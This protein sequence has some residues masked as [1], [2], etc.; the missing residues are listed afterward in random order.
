VHLPNEMSMSTKIISSTTV[1]P[2]EAM[3]KSNN[4]TM[5][6]T[7]INPSCQKIEYPSLTSHLRLKCPQNC[8]YRQYGEHLHLA[9]KTPVNLGA[10]DFIE[11]PAP[12]WSEARTQRTGHRETPSVNVITPIHIET[13]VPTSTSTK[14]PQTIKEETP[15]QN[16]T[17]QKF[18]VKTVSK[19]TSY[20][21]IQQ[22]VMAN[23]AMACPDHVLPYTSISGGNVNYYG[24]APP[25]L[26]SNATSHPLPPVI[27][28]ND[29]GAAVIIRPHH[30]R[31][32]SGT[33]SR[34]CSYSSTCESPG[35]EM[36]GGEK[37][38]PPGVL[39]DTNGKHWI[40]DQ[41]RE[42]SVEDLQQER[43]QIWNMRNS[44]WQILTPEAESCSY[45]RR[46]LTGKVEYLESINE[47]SLLPQ[48]PQTKPRGA[49][50]EGTL[51][52]AH[53]NIESNRNQAAA[54]SNFHDEFRES[55]LETPVEEGK[56]G[57]R[58][59]HNLTIPP[60]CSKLRQ[61]KEEKSSAE[62]IKSE[63][64]PNSPA[65][66][67]AP[68]YINLYD[69]WHGNSWVRSCG[70]AMYH[71]GVEVYGLEV[72]Y[73]GRDSDR[74]GVYFS[75]PKNGCD[76]QFSQS[77]EVGRTSKSWNKIVSLVM[78]IKDLYRA[79]EYDILYWNCHDFT[80]EF[81]KIL[82]PGWKAP[83]WLNRLAQAGQFLDACSPKCCHCWP[84][85]YVVQSV[86][87]EFVPVLGEQESPDGKKK[88]PK[89][90]C[91]SRSSSL[92]SSKY[93][94]VHYISKQKSWDKGTR[95]LQDEKYVE[96]SANTVITP[97]KAHQ[98]K[99]NYVNSRAISAAINHVATRATSENINH[100]GPSP[101]SGVVVV[102]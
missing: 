76:Q 91:H 36:I 81:V 19:N 84:D 3:K 34:T 32:G 74:S 35:H 59:D 40:D 82:I 60:T 24:N 28:P 38:T 46:P 79:N 22:H 64:N 61:T 85:S 26:P 83:K 102:N 56:C 87:E 17:A 15:S 52:L 97:T 31:H 69:M 100:E 80:Q 11:I 49:E 16:P 5:S 93:L 94:P 8:Q 55:E 29:R 18:S 42:G 10:S 20:Q 73:G 58:A 6:T 9:S 70:C 90:K 48:N 88:T 96:D 62:S 101:S 4:I 25:Y 37:Q 27:Y 7:A 44:G 43:L 78:D 23:S 86:E 89:N 39:V 50:V 41:I 21:P 13:S 92:G 12:P 45:H 53:A 47:D 2:Y 57:Q 99:I 66:E 67:G 75:S 68:V 95:R 14:I 1:S 65:W 54:H 72:A 63:S 33:C 77:L 51:P 71:S 30:S 98:S